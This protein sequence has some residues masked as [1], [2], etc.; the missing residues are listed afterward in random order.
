MFGQGRDIVD[1]AIG[2]IGLRKQ[3]EHIGAVMRSKGGFDHRLKYA[4]V[5]VAAVIA[6]KARICRQFWP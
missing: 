1:R 2:D 3:I 6:D 5:A 4:P